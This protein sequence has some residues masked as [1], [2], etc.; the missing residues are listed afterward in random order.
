MQ[1][2]IEVKSTVGKGTLFAVRVPLGS[3]PRRHIPELLPEP[4]PQTL[5]PLNILCVDNEPIILSSIESL[6]QQW[7]CNSTT[8]SSLESALD[9]A[10]KMTAAPDAILVDYQLDNAVGFEVIEALDNVWE[11][12]VPAIL[13]TADHS[14]DIKQQAAERGYYFLQKPITAESLFTALRNVMGKN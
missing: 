11:D 3:V 9:A 2:P 6:L 1:H 12:V 5:P 14:E 8:A 7:Q 10:G 4:Q 13:M